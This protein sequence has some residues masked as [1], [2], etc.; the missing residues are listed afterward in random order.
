MIREQIL[1]CD[2]E[3]NILLEKFIKIAFTIVVLL[4][5]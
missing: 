1:A 4:P 5:I 2:K 3:L